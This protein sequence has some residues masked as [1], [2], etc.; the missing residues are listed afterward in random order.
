MSR[1]NCSAVSEAAEHYRAG[2][3]AEAESLYRAVLA[4]HPDNVDAIQGLAVLC[5]QRGH[6]DEALALFR[7]AITLDPDSRVADRQLGRLL[8]Q[9]GDLVGAAICYRRAARLRPGDPRASRS[10][11]DARGK[12]S[13]GRL[14]TAGARS[15]APDAWTH[16]A[17]GNALLRRG[18]A[19]SYERALAISPDLA[20]AH[21]NLGEALRRMGRLSE[22]VAAC[23][24]A[25]ALRP[26][27]AEAHNHLGN[28][29]R[30]EGRL[31]PAISHYEQAL[32]L[33]PDWPEVHNNL[34]IALQEQGRT[35]KP[36]STMNGRCRS[37]PA[38]PRCTKIS[39]VRSP[40]PGTRLTRS[41]P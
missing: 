17:L 28:A 31:E 1:K 12:A 5:H 7:R 20:E 3:L 4:K 18:G 25:L 26:E 41:P 13:R 16:I 30:E 37:I 2:R 40:N 39:A 22:A 35:G 15:L 24:R 36:S 32:R 27:L 33:K 6:P 10:C 23:E 11:P 34:A 8:E 19:A 14:G 9:R 21:S 29:L 38:S